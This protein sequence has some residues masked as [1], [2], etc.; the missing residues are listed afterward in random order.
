MFSLS[1]LN[2]HIMFWGSLSGLV[3]TLI[4]NKRIKM[5]EIFL[6]FY[7]LFTI[8]YGFDSLSISG[9]QLYLNDNIFFIS[10][11]ISMFF[12]VATKIIGLL[13]LILGVKKY[14]KNDKD[15]VIG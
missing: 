1:M 7:L 9:Y 15:I 12:S 13:L 6:P 5:A 2:W 8:G 10:G 3:V 11:S 14:A 4:M